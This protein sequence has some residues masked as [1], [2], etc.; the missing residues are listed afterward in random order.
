MKLT[1]N[2]KIFWSVVLLAVIVVIYFKKGYNSSYWVR[3]TERKKSKEKGCICGFNDKGKLVT[4]DGTE[5][6][7]KYEC[8]CCK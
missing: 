8:D 7:C 2:Q 5:R 3:T 4:C 6:N 1:K